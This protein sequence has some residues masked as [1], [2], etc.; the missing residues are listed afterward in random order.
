MILVRTDAPPFANPK[1]WHK[2]QGHIVGIIAEDDLIQRLRQIRLRAQPERVDQHDRV[3]Q[4]VGVQVHAAGIANRVHLQKP[5]ELRM[6]GSGAI[7]VQA[8]F[9][10]VPSAGVQIWIPHAARLLDRAIRIIRIFR[11]RF[12]FR[13]PA[14]STFPAVEAF[15][16]SGKR[17]A[18]L[19]ITPS[20]KA[21]ARLSL[22]QRKRLKAI[23]KCG[24][25]SCSLLMERCRC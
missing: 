13:C 4:G 19:W 17:D 1:G 25:F 5:S 2:E 20:N 7:M 22:R 16:K 23:T 15:V 11:Q 9:F 14:S 10:I 3:V 8:G 21:L 12:V 24:G 18:T 6:I